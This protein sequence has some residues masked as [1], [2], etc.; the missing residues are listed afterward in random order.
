AFVG[1]LGA[2]AWLTQA[3][4]FLRCV[5]FFDQPAPW[6]LTLPAAGLL[7]AAMTVDSAARFALRRQRW[8]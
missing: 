3:V 7:Y 4:L 5:R 2:A 1:G 8:R 6:A